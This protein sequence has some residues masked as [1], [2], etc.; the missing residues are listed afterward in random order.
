[1]EIF[2]ERHHEIGIVLLDMMMPGMDGY[3]TFC[4][5][6][7]IHREVKVLFVSGYGEEEKFTSALKE[8]AL[9]VCNKPIDGTSL[10]QLINDALDADIDVPTKTLHLN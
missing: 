4:A 1:V 6:K 10:S 7:K 2:R 9:G 5:L 3:E 8:G